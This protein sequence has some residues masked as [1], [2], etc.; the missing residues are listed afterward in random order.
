MSYSLAGQKLLDPLPDV[1]S[2]LMSGMEAG[3]CQEEDWLTPLSAGPGGGDPPEGQRDQSTPAP[4]YTHPLDVKC[5]IPA[6]GVDPTAPAITGP[7]PIHPATHRAPEDYSSLESSQSLLAAAAITA[8]GSFTDDSALI[9]HHRREAPTPGAQYRNHTYTAPPG[10]PPPAIPGVRGRWQWVPEVAPSQHQAPVIVTQDPPQELQFVESTAVNVA[11]GPL[12]L[13]MAMEGMD[14]D[15]DLLDNFDVFGMAE[16]LDPAKP[17]KPSRY[18]IAGS[19]PLPALLEDALS[20]EDGRSGG[21]SVDTMQFRA[22]TSS[23]SLDGNETAFHME[24]SASGNLNVAGS[25]GARTTAPRGMPIPGARNTALKRSSSKTLSSPHLAPNLLASSLPTTLPSER[26][27]RSA[28]RRSIALAAAALQNGSDS[29]SED[30]SDGGMRPASYSHGGSLRRVGSGAR[31]GSGHIGGSG[32]HKKKHNPWS[33]EETLALVEGVR[34]AGPGKWAEIKRLP[35]PAVA[36]ILEHRSP[37][38]LKDKWRNLTRV[39]RLPKATLKARLGRAHSDVP[40][41]TM[42][43]VKQLMEAG[44]DVE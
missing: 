32:S 35:V 26:P 42:L 40:L 27:M 4:N 5:Q 9:H 38:D 37:V 3:P 28:A 24:R 21:S 29:D 25:L 14:L 2:A 41:E 8:P 39:A 34:L 30:I 23:P 16:S 19:C 1:I 44:L 12:P 31:L 7:L 13:P 17:V 36:N 22:N 15:L 18:R 33:L 10:P 20:A 6:G 43:E 11:A